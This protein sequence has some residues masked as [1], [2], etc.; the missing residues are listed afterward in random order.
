M[1]KQAVSYLAN[2]AK[3]NDMDLDINL[4][5]SDNDEAT[6]DDWEAGPDYES[7]ED[8][9][10][11]DQVNEDVGWDD[12][13]KED[14]DLSFDGDGV[15]LPQG[16]IEVVLAEAETAVEAAAKKGKTTADYWRQAHL[17]KLEASKEKR[18]AARGEDPSKVVDLYQA[19]KRHKKANGRLYALKDCYTTSQVGRKIFG[20]TD[21]SHIQPLYRS[22]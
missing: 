1:P 21:P 18:A 16:P 13:P 10:F 7:L 22:H 3:N 9:A 14:E 19:S 2:L 5:A 17:M 6:E 8:G 11:R 4:Y 15:P 20:R 12:D